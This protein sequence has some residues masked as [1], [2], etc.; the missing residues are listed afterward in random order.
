MEMAC[1]DDE[2]V[3]MSIPS[4][5]CRSRGRETST[6]NI[7]QCLAALM[8]LNPHE[9]GIA[10]QSI[11]QVRQGNFRGGQFCFVCFTHLNARWASWQA[12]D[13]YALI[14]GIQEDRSRLT[15][16]LEVDVA[17]PL[18]LVPQAFPTHPAGITSFGTAA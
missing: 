4:E 18:T 16:R 7:V 5:R 15:R 14:P 13:A 2:C 1:A 8:H 3:F 12:R 6:R 11:G 17:S 9:G 10:V